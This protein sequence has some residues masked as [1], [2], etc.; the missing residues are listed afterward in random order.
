MSRILLAILFTLFAAVPGTLARVGTDH[1]HAPSQRARSQFAGRAERSRKVR[2]AHHKRKPLAVEGT[3]KDAAGNLKIVDRIPS[4]I[5]WENLEMIETSST[6][7]VDG[8]KINGASN[9]REGL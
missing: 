7:V 4:P 9:Q 8:H 1:Y 6:G 2:K 3:A 5:P